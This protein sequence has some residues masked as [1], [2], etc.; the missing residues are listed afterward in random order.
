MAMTKPKKWCVVLAA[1]LFVVFLVL[2]W[3]LGSALR[4]TVEAKIADAVKAPVKLGGLSVRLLPPGAVLSDLEVGAAM[5]ET[6]GAPLARIPSLSLSVSWGTVFGGPVHVTSLKASNADV[7]LA[8]DAQGASL[9]KKFL[10]NI[11]PSDRKDP[12]PIDDLVIRNAKA[13]LYVPQE[14]L[15]PTSKVGLEP[16][17]ATLDY[18]HVRDLIVP[19]PDKPA[20]QEQWGAVDVEGLRIRAPLKGVN[21][22]ASPPEAGEAIEEGVALG[23]FGAEFSLPTTMAGTAKFRGGHA[24]GLKVRNVLTALDVPETLTRINSSLALCLAG[25]PEKKPKTTT[26]LVGSGYV[27]DLAVVGSA[28][29]I[30]G[31]DG[32]GKPCFWRLTDLKVEL[33][34]IPLGRGAETPAAN[35]G[36]LRLSSP[37]K[38]SEGDGNLLVEWTGVKGRYPELDFDLKLEL[39]GMALTPLSLRVEEA[40]HAGMVKGQMACSFAGPTRQGKLG[41]DGSATISKD[42]KLSGKGVSGSLVSSLATVATGNPIKTIR[43]RGTLEKPEIQP[44]DFVAGAVANL[45]E[46]VLTKGSINPLGVFSDS[47]GAA[48]DQGMREGQKV[49][50]KVPFLGGILG[51]KEESK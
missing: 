51:G 43:I 33:Q 42:T 48:V 40:V 18:A 24:Q 47:M 10:D 21:A 39:S 3:V 49:L 12:L 29:E 35:P 17:T 36:L 46:K 41:W 32:N 45:F 28:F 34:R 7:A 25:V 27:E 44:P 23:G 1:I 5:P 9:F 13:V 6:G 31:P 22:P 2:P 38:S 16:V 37:S 11:P 8:C 19:P 15:A 20:A 50:K 30:S 14:L 26:S 4:G